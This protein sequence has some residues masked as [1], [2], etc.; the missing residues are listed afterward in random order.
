MPVI[1]PSFTKPAKFTG[2]SACSGVVSGKP[3]FSSKDAVNSTVPCILIREETTPDDVAG[4]M[5]AKGIITMTGGTTSHAAVVARGFNKPCITGVGVNIIDAFAGQDIITMDGSTGR[6]WFETV[7]TLQCNAEVADKFA[8]MLFHTHGVAPIIYQT[9]KYEMDEALLYFGGE[10]VDT[11]LIYSRICD[12][13][14]KV[15][16]LYVDLTQGVTEAERAFH[17]MFVE[18]N[19]ASVIV[20]KLEA[21]PPANKIILIGA[22]SNKYKSIVTTESLETVILAKS[23]IAVSGTAT[24]AMKRVLDWKKAEGLDIMTIGQKGEGKSIVSFEELLATV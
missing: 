1:D 20:D 21:N 7:P 19:S 12:A 10:L 6:I 2:L 11:N 14:L 15:K 5:A 24:P 3:V 13:S 23:A 4:M 8:E 16:T 17:S 18:N 22:V 9:P